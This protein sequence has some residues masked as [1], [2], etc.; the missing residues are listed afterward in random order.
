MKS[1]ADLDQ[2]QLYGRL[3]TKIGSMVFMMNVVKLY[4][5][6]FCVDLTFESR[7]DSDPNTLNFKNGLVDTRTGTFRLRTKEDL[8]SKVLNYDY[9]DIPEAAVIAKVRLLLVRICND[10]IS[11]LDYLCAYLGYNLTGYTR[12]QKFMVIVGHLASNGKST[13]AKMFDSAFSISDS[14]KLDR[15][16]FNVDYTKHEH[17]QFALIKAPVRFV[18]IEELDKKKLDTQI[19]KDF[20]DGNKVNNGN[21]VWNIRKHSDTKQIKLHF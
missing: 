16:T 12:E 1:L 4:L 18:Y 10:D 6:T 15:Q 7:L 8:V 14:T 11:L 2:L 3:I 9:S 20:V 21:N 5:M 13:T 17:K 19:L